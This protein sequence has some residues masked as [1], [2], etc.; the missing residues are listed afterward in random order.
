MQ[1]NTIL[2][3]YISCEFLALDIFITYIPYNLVGWVAQSV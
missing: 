1:L 2:Y 3:H